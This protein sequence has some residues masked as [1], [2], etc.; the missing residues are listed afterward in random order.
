MKN[1]I[2][3]GLLLLFLF[4]LYLF[5]LNNRY[6]YVGD[7]KMGLFDKWTEQVI[8]VKNSDIKDQKQ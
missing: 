7:S 8:L 1:S 2:I 4:V 3:V 6:I 5:A